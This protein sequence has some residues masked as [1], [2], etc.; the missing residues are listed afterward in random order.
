MLANLADEPIPDDWCYVYN[1][2]QPHKP[3][4]HRLPPGRAVVFRDD[5]KQLSGELLTVLP[6]TFAGE[7]YQL[8]KRGLE[9]ELRG[10]HTEAL[11][12]LREEAKSHQ[13]ALL[14]FLDHLFI[15]QFFIA[16]KSLF[17][18][19]RRTDQFPKVFFLYDVFGF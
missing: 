9:E 19:M 7:E 3:R 16:L 8:Q 1:F 13:I 17:D 12:K 11:D 5:M 18:K 10:M 2:E 14:E 6:A 4:A 15:R